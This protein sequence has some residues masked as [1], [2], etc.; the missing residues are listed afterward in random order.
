M[1]LRESFAVLHISYGLFS[2][3]F[4]GNVGG[5]CMGNKGNMGRQ[6]DFSSNARE[7]EKKKEGIVES[8]RV[9]PRSSY[10]QT[11]LLF[12]FYFSITIPLRPFNSSSFFLN[13]EQITTTNQHKNRLS[14]HCGWTQNMEKFFFPFF[15]RR[16]F[17]VLFNQLSAMTSSR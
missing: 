12:F 10:F 14:H 17:G 2:S 8:W 13:K 7:R 9:R 6:M 5:S 15:F 3:F 1:G 4:L 16:H 11:L